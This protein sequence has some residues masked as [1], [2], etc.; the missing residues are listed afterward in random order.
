M[1]QLVSATALAVCER[2]AFEKMKLAVE[3]YC[4]RECE[5]RV[6]QH[7]ISNGFIRSKR[8][9]TISRLIDNLLASQQNQG[10]SF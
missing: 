5:Q 4:L 10:N 1:R 3:C 8:E 9:L 2:V 6:R 7:I